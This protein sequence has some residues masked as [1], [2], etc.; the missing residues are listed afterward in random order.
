M[1]HSDAIEAGGRHAVLQAPRAA[2]LTFLNQAPNDAE[3]HGDP[4]RILIQVPVM[5][6]LPNSSVQ[7]PLTCLN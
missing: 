7:Q 6:E 3:K 5:H 4:W 2:R 1:W